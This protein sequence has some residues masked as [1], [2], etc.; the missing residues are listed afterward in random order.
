MNAKP[1]GPVQPITLAHRW[2][3]RSG[4]AQHK[5]SGT[6]RNLVSEQELSRTISSAHYKSKLPQ[7]G[8]IDDKSRY[9][10]EPGF[11]SVVSFL[12]VWH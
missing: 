4:Y 9:H 1:G 11:L 8:L 5:R 3:V 6:E 2:S 12:H 10:S 7:G